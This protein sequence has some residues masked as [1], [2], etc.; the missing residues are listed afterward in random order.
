MAGKA[1]ACSHSGAVSW[2]IDMAAQRGLTGHT[3]TDAATTRNRGTKRNVGP[4]LIH[5]I[6]FKL[7]CS[8]EQPDTTIKPRPTRRIKHFGSREAL[9]GHIKLSPAFQDLFHIRG[10]CPLRWIC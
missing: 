1:R 10:R 3:Y 6:A 7:E 4:A 2:K 9:L 8:S 5:D